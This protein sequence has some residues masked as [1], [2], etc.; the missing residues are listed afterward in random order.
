MMT[1]MMVCPLQVGNILLVRMV[2][3]IVESESGVESRVAC[4]FML[5]RSSSQSV[6]NP[7]RPNHRDRANLPMN[8]Y[9]QAGEQQRL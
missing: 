8:T 2:A 1:V 6:K 9:E 5:L 4:T 7:W 3:T